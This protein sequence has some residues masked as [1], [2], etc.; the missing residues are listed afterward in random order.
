MNVENT[1]YYGDNLDIL[2]RYIKDETID[3]VYLDPP[4]KSNQN[5]N[6]LFKEKNG[7]QAASQI[8]AFEDTWTWGQD[9]EVVY[10]DLVTKGGKVADCLQAFRTFM[11]PCDMLAYLVMMAPRLIELRRVLKRTG[12]IYLHCDPAASHYLKMLLDA[13]FGPERFVNEIIWKRTNA[14]G[15]AFTRF[16]GDHDT[17]LRYSKSDKWIW[18]P[19]YTEHNPEYVRKFY[20]FIEP[21]TGRRYT[22]DN[23]LNPNKDRPNLTYEFLGITRVWRWTKERMNEAYQKG[24]VIQSAP[25]RVPRLKRY[26]DEQEGTPIDDVWGDIKPIQAQ[27]AE[28]L[29][30]PTQKPEALLDRI[31]KASSNEG[32]LV[33]DPFC[34]CG[35][36]VA[37]AQK[38]KRRWVGIDITHLAITLMKKRLLDAFG[39]E[40][41]FN[42]MGEP[43]SLPDAAALAE[44][45]PYQFQWWA[46]GLVGARPVEQKKGADK[47]IDGKII[48]QGDE[49]GK[50]E[51]VILSV[52]AGHTGRDHV[53]SLRG[54]MDG[55][56][57]AIGVLISMQNPTGPMKEEAVTAGFFESKTWGKKY[58]KI[59]LLTIA[60]LLAGKK[61]DMPPIKQVGAT[62]KKAERF[63]GD[64]A[65]QLALGE[66]GK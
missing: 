61:V 33:L 13:I 45:D 4:F 43:T 56:K 8:R 41:K 63:K 15:L 53:H 20:R 62:F 39:T 52:K 48:F 65:E 57:A 50:F 26:L 31:I 21:E 6:V 24:V 22:L 38:L 27:A 64:R 9:D 11:G 14:K 18:N 34:G 10:A 37:A 58:P 55:Q 44:S 2:R 42:V 51:Q 16:A 35:T 25:G 47:G 49:T 28:R 19:V 12:S 23:L 3:L 46:L 7:S 29:G 32:D 17:L 5:Y 30:Y 40:A 59:Q 36:T 66:K 1:L 54:V 60:E